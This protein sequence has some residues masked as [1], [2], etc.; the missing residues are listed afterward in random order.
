MAK[1]EKTLLRECGLKVT[2]ARVAILHYLYSLDEPISAEDLFR[3]VSFS[4]VD[5]STLYRTLNTFVE[6]GIAKK[7]VG[8]R[9][10]NLYMLKSSEVEHLMVCLRCG[11]KVPL[12]GCP[13]HEVNERLE[14][15]TG[16]HVLDHNTEIYGICPDCQKARP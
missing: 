11:K 4:E 7:E 6:V 13:Y 2:P 1:D 15:E 16:F 5:L 10:E 3:S 14:A 9:K 12:A 8:R